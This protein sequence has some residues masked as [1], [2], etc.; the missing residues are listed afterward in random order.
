MAARLMYEASAKY[1][2]AIFGKDKPDTSERAMRA[3]S[4]IFT[5]PGH[6]WNYQN[7]WMAV[8]EG[9]VMGLIVAYGGREMLK[10]SLSLDFARA[11]LRELSLLKLP[12]LIRLGGLLA[13]NSV[14][15]GPDDFYIDTLAVL[16]QYRRRGLGT[17]MLQF[18][19]EL[20]R[21]GQYPRLALDVLIDNKEARL[22]YH[23]AGFHILSQVEDRRL[24]HYGIS[25]SIRMIKAVKE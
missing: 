17:G 7:A 5:L 11:W 20:A 9:E 21:A 25:G 19:L 15:I 23:Q 8:R 1:M 13:R 18:A 12:R 22:F 10:P 24:K 4:S 6:R 3:F 16:P 2:L 14:P